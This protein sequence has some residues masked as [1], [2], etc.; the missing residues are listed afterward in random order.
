VLGWKGEEEVQQEF[1]LQFSERFLRNSISSC[2]LLSGNSK[3][4]ESHP[5]VLKYNRNSK[6]LAI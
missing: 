4:K 1:P 5:I 2:S 3:R 6:A